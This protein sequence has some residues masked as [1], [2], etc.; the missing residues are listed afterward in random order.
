[1]KTHLDTGER[2]K[3]RLINFAVARCG[4]TQ[5][6]SGL[7]TTQIPARVTCKTCQKL[8]AQDIAQAAQAREAQRARHG[9]CQDCGDPASGT[10]WDDKPICN[11]CCRKRSDLW[12][13]ALTPSQPGDKR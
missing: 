12:A 9:S 1:M 3:G 13:K 7:L 10:T 11:D 5:A 2:I 8:M 6:D 4:K